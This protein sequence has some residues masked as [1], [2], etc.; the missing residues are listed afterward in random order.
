MPMQHRRQAQVEKLRTSLLAITLVFGLMTTSPTLSQVLT[1]DASLGIPSGSVIFLSDLNITTSGIL[2]NLL[3]VTITANPAAEV[4]LA[5]AFESDKFGRILEATSKPF[6]LNGSLTFDN[7]VFASGGSFDIIKNDPS[8]FRAYRIND[9]IEEITRTGRLPDDQY[10]F[11]LQLLPTNPSIP[12][13]QTTVPLDISNPTTLSLVSPGGV[14]GGS[15]CYE[16]FT[17][18]P[19]FQWDSNADRFEITI[20]EQLP[21]NSTPEDVMQN[22]PRVQMT[23]VSGIDFVGK[24]SFLYPASGVLPLQEGH[25][26]YWQVNGIVDSPSGQVRLPSE[27]WC[28]NLASLGNPGTG[29]SSQQLLNALVNALGGGDFDSL[30]AAGGP[31]EGYSPTGV[32]MLDGK[33][34]DMAALMQ[35]LNQFKNGSRKVKG[36]TVE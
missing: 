25:T 3:Q 23:L 21:T 10:R 31:L 11:I 9:L 5:F 35:F 34:V 36:I 18:L 32:I 24:P 16:L 8:K 22:Q 27:I 28:F 12:P 13:D 2:S 33:R 20:C 19:L 30:F 15:E 4:T 14:A 1:I 6:T 17:T 26:Y 29:L 7:R